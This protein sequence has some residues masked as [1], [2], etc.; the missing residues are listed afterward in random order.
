MPSWD[1]PVGRYLDPVPQD[2][3]SVDAELQLP[4]LFHDRVFRCWLDQ[5][6]LPCWTGHGSFPQHAHY[7]LAGGFGEGAHP[8]ERGQFFWG[9]RTVG[10]SVSVASVMHGVYSFC[11]EAESI[12]AKLKRVTE[13]PQTLL[14][15]AEAAAT[16]QSSSCSYCTFTGSC[17]SC[18]VHLLPANHQG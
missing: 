12:A 2:C 17:L 5:I 7:R 11:S 4:S 9:R 3:T 16:V 6:S 10:L 18:V 13:C 14:G 1:R 8:Y 15:K